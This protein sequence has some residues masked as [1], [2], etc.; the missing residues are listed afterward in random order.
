MT[1]TWISGAS[2]TETRHNIAA[3]R[4]TTPRIPR[5]CAIVTWDNNRAAAQWWKC[6][7]G[8]AWQHHWWCRCCYMWCMVAL[9]G[10]WSMHWRGVTLYC[11]PSA[12]WYW[13]R[14]METTLTCAGEWRQS[15]VD[16][17]CLGV[18]KGEAKCIVM[19]LF[20]L[21]CSSSLSWINEYLTIYSGGYVYEQPSCINCSRWLD[22]SQR[23]RDGV[24]VNRSVREVKCKTL[25]MVLR[26]GYCAI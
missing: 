19:C 24:W 22:A 10:T 8:A 25:W 5:L 6:C 3:A 18:L 11:R 1:T 21:H 4:V 13:P 12:R 17:A 14:R 2:A 23:S 26:T 20:T 16:G 7:S 9:T 15:P